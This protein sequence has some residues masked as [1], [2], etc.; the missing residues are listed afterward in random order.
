M[1]AARLVGSSDI[2]EEAKV[3]SVV[4]GAGASQQPL[5]DATTAPVAQPGTVT[6]LLRKTVQRKHVIND[7]NEANED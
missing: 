4:A 2:A 7:E 6:R 1:E 5:R 3:V